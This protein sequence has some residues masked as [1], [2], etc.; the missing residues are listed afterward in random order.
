[1][2]R[3]LNHVKMSSQPRKKGHPSWPW[4]LST[5]DRHWACDG[6]FRPFLH[7]S[8]CWSFLPRMLLQASSQLRE[9]GST[10][11]RRLSI[12]SALPP[13]SDLCIPIKAATTF[14]CWKGLFMQETKTM[15]VLLERWT[16]VAGMKSVWCLLLIAR[17]GISLVWEAVPFQHQLLLGSISTPKKHG[18]RRPEP[19]ARKL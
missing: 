6:I 16:S 13:E 7:L 15:K 5:R 18:E 12:N 4:M 9:W 11:T 3:F 1:M 14:S 10:K 2:A 19:L 8:V 17:E